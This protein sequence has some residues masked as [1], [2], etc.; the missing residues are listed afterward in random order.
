MEYLR[1]KEPAAMYQEETTYVKGA[2]VLHMIR[3]FLGEADFDRMIAAY[4]QKHEYSNVDSADLKEAIERAAG[5]NLTGS[6]KTGS[7]AAAGT[8]GSRC[9][10]N[11]RPSGNRST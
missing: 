7:S 6:S 2:L 1:Y 11:G 9:P 10:T 3:H 8:P 5:R 4:L